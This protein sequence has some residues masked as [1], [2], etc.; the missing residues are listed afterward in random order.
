MAGAVIRVAAH[1][2]LSPLGATSAENFEA[3]TAGRSALQLHTDTFG[4]PEPFC[5]S[6]F[7]R[8]AMEALCD[9]TLAHYAT[10]NNL[11]PYSPSAYT[12]LEKLCLLSACKALEQCN[13]SPAAPSTLFILSTTKGNVDALEG[14]LA[15]PRA[16]LGESGAAI[17]RFFGNEN[18]VAVVSNACISGVCAQIEG[19][20][21]LLAGRCTHAVVVGADLLSRFIVS[22][23]Q[24]FKALSP[25][26]CKPFSAD[27]IGL[28]L[29]EAV[30]T[31]VLEVSTEAPRAHEWTYVA[32]A[33]HND[34]NHISGPS[35]TGEGSY[36]VLRHLLRE[37]SSE[38]LAMV[39]VHGTSTPYND[40][41]ESIAL[42]RA[43]LGAI[44]VSALKGYYGH[45]LG[46][47][48]IVETI[49]TLM[50]ADH[51]VVPSSRGFTTPGTTYP[52]NIA[53]APRPTAAGARSFIKLLSGFGGTNAGIAYR[54]GGCNQ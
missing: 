10:T 21:A 11:L 35:R 28:N 6:L 2:I 40:E 41:M 36:R 27:R 22:G 9:T 52:V 47:A 38:E 29:G 17:G 3:V 15:S 37:L 43:D 31:L 8:P 4:V 13:I 50:A 1:N 24:S 48:G 32:G 45:T 46:A 54:K 16:Y 49:I 34:A 33:I 19:V 51:G 30:A 14:D 42:H 7:N 53:A 26:P 12:L 5:A 20:R 18:P 25:E 23:F 44:P 39:N